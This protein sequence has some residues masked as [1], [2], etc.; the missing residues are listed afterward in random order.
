VSKCSTSALT[1]FSD[2]RSAGNVSAY[3]KE[4]RLHMVYRM[5][6]KP[7]EY[8]L[9]EPVPVNTVTSSQTWDWLMGLVPAG[10]VLAWM[11]KRADDQDAGHE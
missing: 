9:P 5:E 8:S 4:E 11:W 2:G 3:G 7:E 10:I 1:Y 6:G